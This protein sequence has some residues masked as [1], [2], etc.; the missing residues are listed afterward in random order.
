MFRAGI[1]W[2]ALV[3]GVATVVAREYLRRPKMAL[4]EDMREA[5]DILR[6]MLWENRATHLD[7]MLL[8]DCELHDLTVLLIETAGWHVECFT[9]AALADDP[10]VLCD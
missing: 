10:L 9:M 3:I 6:A 5:R 7:R 8:H 2:A 1:D 4:H